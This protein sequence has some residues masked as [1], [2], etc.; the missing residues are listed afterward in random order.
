MVPMRT[1]LRTALRRDEYAAPVET[2]SAIIDIGSNSVRL[3]VYDGPR[4]IP[5]ILFN[6]KVM[7]GLGASLGKTG[8]IEPGAMKRS[9][10]A[11]ARYKHLCE[12]MGVAALRCVATAAVRDASNGREFLVRAK[13]LGLEVELLSGAQEGAASGYGVISAIPNANG[14]VGDLGGGSLELVR[15]RDGEV[16]DIMS[17]P[18]GVLR[19]PEIRAKGNGALERYVKKLLK[20]RA[21]TQ[22]SRGFPSI[23]SEDRGD[24]LR[25]WTCTS[26][27]SRCRSSIIMK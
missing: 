25:G 24:R 20:K 1:L 21:G 17:L 4:R 14:I 12:E 16:H 8:M 6:E 10:A 5:F 15:V 19:L 2:R 26:I 18:L 23:S 9:L 13:A 22:P 11:L 3:V 7:A 27:I